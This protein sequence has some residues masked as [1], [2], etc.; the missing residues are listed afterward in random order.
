MDKFPVYFRGKSIGEMTVEKGDCC[1]WFTVQA[2]LPGEE[3][4]CAW[5]LGERTE[6]RLGILESTGLGSTIR[7]K[8]SERMILPLGTIRGAEIRTVKTKNSGWEPVLNVE[9]F[10]RSHRLRKCFLGQ[11]GLL[12]KSRG[13]SCY[14]AVPYDKEKGFAAIEL[15]CF[16]RLVQ[17]E[18]KE[19]LVIL[20]NEE[21]QVMFD[22]A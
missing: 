14:I 22:G 12:K 4:L 8:F 17:I 19:Y 9:T 1:A 5:V 6:L 2:V 11:R 10:F 18:T 3:L 16:A 20:F 13:R 21:E 7:R 15:F